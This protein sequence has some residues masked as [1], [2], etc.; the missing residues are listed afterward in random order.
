MASDALTL[1]KIKYI[2]EKTI[3][4]KNILIMKL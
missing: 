3:I 2:N 1:K 4:N